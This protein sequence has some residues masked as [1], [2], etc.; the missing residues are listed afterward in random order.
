VISVGENEFI[1]VAAEELKDDELIHLAEQRGY[2]IHKPR[3]IE[4]PVLDVSS[5]TGRDRLKFAV[6]S[7]THFGSKYQQLTALREFTQYADRVTKVDLFIHAGDFGDGPT[8]RHKNPQDVFKHDYES[9]LDY[10]VETLPRTRKPWKII[11]GNHDDWWGIDGGPDIIKTLCEQRDDCE[12]LGKSLGYLNFKDTLIEVTHL[13]TGSAYAYSYK[14]QKHIE[15]LSV[16]RR[17]NVS[18][19]GNFHKFC[20]IYY[21]NVL[22]IQLP[23]FQAQTP[24]MAGKSLVSEVGGVI[25]EVGLHRKGLTPST[26]FEVVYTF[27]PRANDWP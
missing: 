21:R 7:C 8:A 17:P 19:I 5:L 9:H 26:Q 16:E 25:V 13:N 27:T 1:E 3:P 24:W 4:T 23:S 2:V 10:Y 11:S 14:P 12:Y 15:S 20:A 22:A 6:V 18:L